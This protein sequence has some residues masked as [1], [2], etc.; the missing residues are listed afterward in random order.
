MQ[1][2][3]QKVID[4]ALSFRILFNIMGDIVTSIAETNGFW[5]PI[6]DQLPNKGEKIALMHSELSECLE[7][8]RKNLPSDHL[9]GMSMEVEE[10]AD[11]VIRIMDYA[12]HYGLPLGQA[13]T[14]KIKFNATRE[15][16]HGK[17][18]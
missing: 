5:E 6:D 4:E 16:K 2:Y 17:K 8:I 18:F 12:Q 10:L 3:T 15:Y 1:N 7:G 13:I 11:C 14:D 9:P